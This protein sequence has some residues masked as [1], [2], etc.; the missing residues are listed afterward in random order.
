MAA[1]NHGVPTIAR[2]RHAGRCSALNRHGRACG[3]WARPGETTCYIHSIPEEERREMSSRGGRQ[4]S[5]TYQLAR[6]HQQREEKVQLDYQAV[7]AQRDRAEAKL[8]Q[9]LK[10]GKI[11]AAD[12]RP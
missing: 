5:L 3:A 7:V 2:S 9:L 6:L 12:L 1:I 10:E 4:R 8:M 11:T